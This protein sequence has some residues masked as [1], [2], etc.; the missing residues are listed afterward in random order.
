MN[1]KTR[2]RFFAVAMLLPVSF[3]FLY[4][5]N[6]NIH[7]QLTRTI[8]Q[9]NRNTVTVQAKVHGWGFTAHK[10]RSG[11]S[12]TYAYGVT[13]IFNKHTYFGTVKIV[14]HTNKKNGELYYKPLPQHIPLFIDTAQPQKYLY[15]N[16]Q[17]TG[18]QMFSI[19]F[20]AIM[21][22]SV[23]CFI[24]PYT[25]FYFK[26]P[27]RGFSAASNNF[28]LNL[29]AFVPVVLCY[30]L[31]K[32]A[33][34]GS[35]TILIDGYKIISDR[36]AFAT[37]IFSNVTTYNGQTTDYISMEMDKKYI[38]SNDVIKAYSDTSFDDYDELLVEK[39]EHA[40][41]ITIKI[42]KTPRQGYI[43]IL[44]PNGNYLATPY[45]YH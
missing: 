3:L 18:S 17:E 28:V 37:Q 41:S 26:K 43:Y 1:R 15:N 21:V 27:H 31:I 14:S 19:I 9:W 35:E 38:Q 40:S 5:I 16:K 20:L 32:N 6:T 45:L 7:N 44:T 8:F 22:A 29:L 25:S 12:F 39:T 33:R 30:F 11:S 10:S 42:Y 24:R 13:Y 34:Q 23:Y 2:N 4:F 36:T